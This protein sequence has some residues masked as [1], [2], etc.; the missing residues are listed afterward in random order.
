M[1]ALQVMKTAERV[2]GPIKSQLLPEGWHRQGESF[3]LRRG[4]V[5]S[6]MN[7]S[8][9]CLSFIVINDQELLSDWA[10][11]VGEDVFIHA[12]VGHEIVKRKIFDIGEQVTGA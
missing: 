4:F 10:V 6:Q 2:V 12:L 7:S 8:P 1:V 9:G 3:L 5:G 11:A